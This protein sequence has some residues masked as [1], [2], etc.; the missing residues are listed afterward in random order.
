MDTLQQSPRIVEA[1][2]CYRRD[3]ASFAGDWLHRLLDGHLYLDRDGSQCKLDVYYDQAEP[4]VAN[5][6]AHLEPS[7]HSTRALIVL[8]S[9][10]LATNFSKGE[11]VDWAHREIDWWTELV[12]EAQYPLHASLAGLLLQVSRRMVLQPLVLCLLASPQ[13]LWL[14]GVP[15][16][17]PGE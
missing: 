12:S 8:C 7:L 15:L 17:L 2:I 3:D 10:G 6:K 1:F 11:V 16:S 5:W 4:G 13:P 9:H 14:F